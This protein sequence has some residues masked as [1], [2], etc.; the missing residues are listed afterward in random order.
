R[1]AQEFGGA[2]RHFEADVLAGAAQQDRAEPLPQLIEVAVAEHLP[3]LVEDAVLTEEAEAR[4]EPAVVDELPAGVQLA[5]PVLQRRARQHQGEARLEPLDDAARLRLPV[6]DA[7]PLVQD[8]EV[9]RHLLDGEDVLEDLL[10][11]TNRE[12]A[13]ATVLQG[14]SRG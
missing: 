1:D 5:E 2:L 13:A 7:L 10:V 14:P 11:V 8:D 4:T 6:L 12:E 3:L 9:P